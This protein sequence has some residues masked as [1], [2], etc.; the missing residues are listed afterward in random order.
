VCWRTHGDQKSRRGCSWSRHSR[1]VQD[2]PVVFRHSLLPLS[3][4]LKVIQS[5]PHRAPGTC[6]PLYARC[7]PG[8]AR[9]GLAQKA[10]CSSHKRRMSSKKNSGSSGDAAAQAAGHPLHPVQPWWPWPMPYHIIFSSQARAL[11]LLRLIFA[12]ISAL[13]KHSIVTELSED[14]MPKGRLLDMLRKL[15]Y[16]HKSSVNKAH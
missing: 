15:F 6:L 14:E 9:Q 16:G 1:F 10:P 7:A 13:R 3:P 11:R 4:E 5:K 2:S 8:L 12:Q